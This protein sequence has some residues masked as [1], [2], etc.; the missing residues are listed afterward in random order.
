MISRIRYA[1]IGTT[2]FAGFDTTLHSRSFVLWALMCSLSASMCFPPPCHPLTWFVVCDFRRT[3][4]VLPDAPLI[5]PRESGNM[6]SF[7]CIVIQ[8]ITLMIPVIRT[9]TGFMFS[10]CSTGQLSLKRFVWVCQA[11]HSLWGRSWPNSTWP[12]R[13]IVTTNDIHS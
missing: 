6:V 10:I 1:G 3:W 9:A 12:N 13:V 11:C 5:R 7:P 8:T 4:I 2:T